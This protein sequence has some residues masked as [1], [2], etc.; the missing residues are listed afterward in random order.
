MTAHHNTA[1]ANTKGPDDRAFLG[2]PKGLGYLALVEG[3]E[4]FSYY[5]MQALLT[6]YMYKYLLL[7]EHI[8]GVIGLDW[9]R[10]WHYPGLSGQP[11]GSAI[12]GDYTSF[13]YLTPIL[14]GMLA[15]RWLG[16]RA[17]LI[18]GG[19]IMSLG[20]FMMALEGTFLFAL[21]ALVVGVGLFKGNIASQVGELYEQGDNRRATAFQIYYLAISASVIVAP[22]IAGTLGE[23]IGWHYGFGAAGIVMVLALLL[24]LKAG[25]WLPPEPQRAGSGNGDRPRLQTGDGW[26]IAALGILV[27]IIALAHLVNQQIFNVFMVWGDQQFDLRLGTFTMPTT[28]LITFD[29]AIAFIIMSL[30]VL[31]WKWFGLRRREPDELSKMI[32]GSLFTISGGLLLVLIA[33]SYPQQAGAASIPLYWP[34]LFIVINEIGFANISPVGL[35]LFSRMA[36]AAIGGTVIGIFYLSF[37]L[38]NKAVGIVGEWYA[39]MPTASFW[40]IHVGASAA[41]LIAFVLF[42]LTLS[43]LLDED[44]SSRA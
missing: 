32:I 12:F 33:T 22:L 11:L 38:C 43:R 29:A 4:R 3:G 1:V 20:H 18:A 35:A 42:K 5:S 19:L 6:L 40:M 17:A 36:P 23:R 21:L 9:L 2:H 37:F 26:R 16:R 8:G 25:P 39:T 10:S 31:F 44:S 41:A 13:V 7:P 28:W 15:D 27:P 30:M 34:L 24:Y 14:G